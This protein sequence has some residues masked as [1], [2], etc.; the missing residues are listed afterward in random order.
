MLCHVLDASKYEECIADYDA[1]R[2]ELGL[3]NP[4]MLEKEEILVLAKCDILDSDMVDDLRS[5]L[6]KK[7]GKKVFAIS[8]PIGV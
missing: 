7:T 1:I 5:Q 2:N 6:E 3:F 4:M 8:A